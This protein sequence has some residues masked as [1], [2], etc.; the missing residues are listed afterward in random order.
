L[1]TPNEGGP[2]EGGPDC[3]P[4]EYPAKFQSG[5]VAKC[6]LIGSVS[7]GGG[8]G[9]LYGGRWGHMRGICETRP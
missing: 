3:A 5:L 9:C 4:P 6:W 1:M 7:P 8:A 2:D